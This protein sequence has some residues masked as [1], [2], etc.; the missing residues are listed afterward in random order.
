LTCIAASAGRPIARVEGLDRG[1]PTL[2]RAE[3]VAGGENVA[4]V[5][6]HAETSRILRRADD[7]AQLFEARADAGALPGRR[8]EPDRRGRFRPGESTVEHPR[9]PP[10]AGG[11]PGLAAGSRMKHQRRN[12]ESLAAVELLGE[13]GGRF[14]GATP[15]RH[16]RR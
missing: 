4:G 2:G 9:D 8:L 12:A 16:P 13:R 3:L 11:R 10:H 5:E 6:A 1:V 15:R 7:V 14:Q